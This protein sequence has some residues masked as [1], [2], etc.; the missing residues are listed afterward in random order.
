[1]SG[2]KICDDE[3]NVD[4][5]VHSKGKLQVA[6][7]LSLVLPSAPINFMSNISCILPPRSNYGGLFDSDS[8]RH[9]K[10]FWK[11]IV[12]M[13]INKDIHNKLLIFLDFFFFNIFIDAFDTLKPMLE[14]I[15]FCF[16]FLS[17]Q[18]LDYFITFDID[19]ITGSNGIQVWLIDEPTYNQFT[20]LG[21]SSLLK[22]HESI[23]NFV[24]TKSCYN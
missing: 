24:R 5:N 19:W 22:L 11:K 4:L 13:Q 16:F 15:K 21:I 17:T 8:S 12:K 6:P 23:K 9:Q 14:V 7:N 1:M 18:I 10:W 3:N 20:K 2:F